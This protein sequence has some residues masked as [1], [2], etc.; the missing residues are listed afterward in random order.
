MIWVPHWLHIDTAV[1]Q[2]HSKYV[3]I[4]RGALPG[5]KAATFLQSPAHI[6]CVGLFVCLSMLEHI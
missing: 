2:L 4:V 6:C 3:P 1:T 5:K